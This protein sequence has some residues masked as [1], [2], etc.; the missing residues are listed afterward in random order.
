MEGQGMSKRYAA[1]VMVSA[2]VV[3]SSA[4]N[5][6]TLRIGGAYYN[7]LDVT[8]IIEKLTGRDIKDGAFVS[9]DV[10]V[11]SSQTR[12]I[13]PQLKVVDGNG[14]KPTGSGTS[15]PITSEDE[16]VVKGDRVKSRFVKQV[17]IDLSLGNPEADYCKEPGESPSVTKWYQVYWRDE[18]CLKSGET[19]TLPYC[20]ADYA[21]IDP[22]DGVMKYLD[23]APVPDRSN[24]TFVFLPLRFAVYGVLEAEVTSEELDYVYAACEIGINPANGL[25]YSLSNPP[26]GGW[27]GPDITKR[28]A[29]NCYETDEFGNR[30]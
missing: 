30:L 1:V 22:A 20:Y 13:N 10:S 26:D 19:G 25:P 6:Q 9:A 3:L 2:G 27:A 15:T 12:C 17:P 23:G 5:A 11:T 4:V 7:T 24:W 14:P 8:T 16:T 28:A 18:G 21:Y 29:Y